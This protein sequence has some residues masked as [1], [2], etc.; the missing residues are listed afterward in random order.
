MLGRFFAVAFALCWL[1]TIPIALNVQGVVSLRL[2]PPPIQYLIGLA[3]I[4]A[5]WWVTRNS[6]E[7]APWLARTFRVRVSA[8]WYVAAIALPWLILAMVMAFDS[9]TGRAL[10]KLWFSPQLGLFGL[11]WLVLA[12]GE[13]AGWRAFALPQMLK[14]RGFWPAATVLG[15]VWCVWHYPRLFSSPYLHFDAP[16]ISALAQFSL[17][18]LVANYLICWFFVRTQSAIVTAVFHASVNTVATAY[19]FAAMD[20]VFTI[21]MAAITLAVVVIDR[22]ALRSASAP[23]AT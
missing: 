20:P 9:A 11:I 23:A 2:L 14:T 15:A 10:P 22:G 4:V 12:F 17:Q 7:R 16:G 8:L 1:I 19:S 21:A 3:P 18:I 5:A 13:E 6:A